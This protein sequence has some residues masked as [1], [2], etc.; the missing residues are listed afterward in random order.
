MRLAR[1]LAALIL[2]ALLSVGCAA[3]PAALAPATL[4]AV[5]QRYVVLLLQLGRVSPDDVDSYYGPDSLKAAAMADSLA[6]TEI[7]TAADSLRGFLGETAPQEWEPLV[8]LRHGFLRRQLA[9]MVARARMLDGDSLSFDQEALALYDMVVTPRPDSVYAAA[10]D[11]IEA[12]LPGAGPLHA[13]VQVFEKQLHIPAARLDTVM[14]VAIEEARRRTREHIALPDSEAFRIEYVKD[15]PW[16]AY[17]WY[18]GGYQS[19]IQVNATFPIHMNRV[20]DLACHEGYPGHHVYGVLLEQEL[21]RK[22]GWVEF[23]AMPLRTPM[24]PIAE[25]TAV[26][27]LDVAFPPAERERWERDVLF[28]LAGLD[29]SLYAR[30]LALQAAMDSLSGWNIDNARDYLDGRRTREQ[31]LAAVVRY[32]LRPPEQADRSVRFYETY[33]AYTVNYGLGK[34]LALDWLVSQG[35]SVDQPARR[36]ELYSQLLGAPKLPHDLRAEIAAAAKRH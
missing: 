29:T 14:R 4:D 13:R 25:G 30:H 22:R 16:S 24:G 28:P 19:L 12:L 15:V 18:Q 34:Q 8:R 17:N 20:L 33:R 11:R 21:V 35:G 31:A 32:G 6:P 1:H 3:R 9:A 5:A 7:A 36:W 2:A 26:V 10:L 23:T 27:A